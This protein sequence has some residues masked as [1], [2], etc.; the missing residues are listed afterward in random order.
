MS[1][2]LSEVHPEL[3]AEWSDKNLPLTPDRITYGSNKV[4]WWKGACGHEWQTTARGDLP[5]WS[6]ELGGRCGRATK[7]RRS[8]CT[9]MLRK[10]LLTHTA[11]SSL[12]ASRSSQVRL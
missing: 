3:V 1:N 9:D 7:T 11:G 2:I 5:I 4:V 10:A 8:V 12:R 6:S